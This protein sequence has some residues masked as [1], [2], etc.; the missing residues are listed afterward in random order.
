MEMRLR[1]DAARVV[2]S[3]QS[4]I[5]TTARSRWDHG[6]QSWGVMLGDR[7]NTHLTKTLWDWRIMKSDR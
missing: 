1:R 7:Q 5:A 2:G 6:K 4:F 3:M